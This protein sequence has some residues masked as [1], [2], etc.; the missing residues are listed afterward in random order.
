[1][2]NIVN[3]DSENKFTGRISSFQS[4]GTVDGPGIRNVVFLQ[5]CPLRCIYC[6]NPETWGKNGGREITEEE[7]LNKIFRYEK[8][9]K[10]NGGV[11]VS[12]GEPL[13]QAQFVTSLFKKLKSN[14][15]HTAIDTSGIGNLKEA[16][17]LMLYCDLIICDLKFTN[18]ADFKRYCAGNLDT[19]LEFLHLS[20]K[21]RKKLWIR[22][23]IVPG[24][25]DSEE[26]VKKLKEIAC[27]HSNLEK[28]ELLPFR[29]LC[30]DKYKEMG[31]E[32]KAENIEECGN[33][34]LRLLQSIVNV[35]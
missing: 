19:V 9:I 3:Y 13:M 14:D 5:G 1:M 28:I 7:L 24:V 20:E 8:Y 2:T 27:R 26:Q 34:R 31:I 18:N 12:G 15:Y 33:D 21:M 10:K 16:E 35:K 30:V 11:T 29:K 6:H 4:M 23:V 17:E 25:N 32:F 22:Q